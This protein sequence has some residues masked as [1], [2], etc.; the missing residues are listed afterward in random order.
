MSNGLLLG[1]QHSAFAIRMEGRLEQ[2]SLFSKHIPRG[3]LVE[4]LSKALLY[5]EVEA[6]WKRDSMANCKAGF[7]LLESHICS[8]DPKAKP[9]QAPPRPVVREEAPEQNVK[10]NGDASIKRKAEAPSAGDGPVEKRA[11]RTPEDMEV[12]SVAPVPERGCRRS[13]DF[14]WRLRINI[15]AL[16]RAATVGTDKAMPPQPKINYPS[17]NKKHVDLNAVRLLPGH[18]AEVFGVI[19]NCSHKFLIQY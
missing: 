11:R 5:V 13:L 10:L 6:H 18:K 4:L 14:I 19:P 7:S 12:D 3:Q 2:S 17:L 9:I 8:L 1:F 15:A 16:E